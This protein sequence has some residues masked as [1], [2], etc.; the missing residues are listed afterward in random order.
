MTILF[1]KLDYETNLSSMYIVVLRA[2]P[3]SGQSI[4]LLKNKWMLIPPI[5]LFSLRTSSCSGHTIKAT[6]YNDV[7]C[8]GSKVYPLQ[9]FPTFVYNYHIFVRRKKV[10]GFSASQTLLTQVQCMHLLPTTISAGVMISQIWT[11]WW[12]LC[13]SEQCG[14]L[15][16][17]KYNTPWTFAIV[18]WM[19]FLCVPTLC[20]GSSIFLEPACIP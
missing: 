6:A 13:I 2:F 7:L 5:C 10:A 3:R 4:F 17:I 14:Y 20:A 15:I 18:I 1:R 19:R 16:S 12:L 9:S 8:V 11:P